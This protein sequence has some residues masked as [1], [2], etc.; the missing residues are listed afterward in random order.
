MDT[1]DA[2]RF[3]K[4]QFKGKSG[5]L[6]ECYRWCIQFSALILKNFAVMFRRPLQLLVFILLP[7]AV[8]LT[9]LIQ[10]HEKDSDGAPKETLYPAIPIEGIGSCDVYYDSSC[11]R[12][13]YGPKTTKT[14]QVMNNFCSLN[15]LDCDK[16][17]KGF[18]TVRYFP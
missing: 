9:F 17:V 16:D 14:I 8:F 1:N 15:D 7:S 3:G 11:V 10:D 6:F 18:D 12:V 4:S 2:L 13:A 5:F